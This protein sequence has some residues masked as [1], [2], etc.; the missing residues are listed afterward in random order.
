MFGD[1]YLESIDNYINLDK[2]GVKHYYTHDGKYQVFSHA[3]DDSE[4][5]LFPSK[6]NRDW[7]TFKVEPQFP[8][9][10]HEC[11]KALGFQDLPEEHQ[12]KHKEMDALCRLLIARDAW[13]KADNNWQPNWEEKTMKYGIVFEHNNKFANIDTMSVSVL[14]AF[15]TPEIRD[16]FHKTFHDL[17]E[18]CKELL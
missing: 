11:G 8:T 7:S 2:D 10:F 3:L 9:E 1:I 16:K 12:Y 13:W 4:C 17:I 6:E 15:R 18:Q 5:T 14:L